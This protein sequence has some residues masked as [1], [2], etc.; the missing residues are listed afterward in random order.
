MSVLP[1]KPVM[2]ETKAQPAKNGYK[3]INYKKEFINFNNKYMVWHLKNF[4]DTNKTV[5]WCP[6]PG[7]E[8][9]IKKKILSDE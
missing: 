9:M 7:C 6:Q 4:T 8:Y 1:N 2:V 3:K 5:K